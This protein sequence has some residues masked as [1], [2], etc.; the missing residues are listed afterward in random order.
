MTPQ[1]R[2]ALIAKIEALPVQL[3]SLLKGVSDERLDRPYRTG[4]WTSRQVV[5]HLADSHMNA[6]IRMRL[7]LTEENPTLRPYN[8]DA[9]A[10]L[11]DAKSG[12]LEPSLTILRGLHKRW[13]AALR[14]VADDAWQRP[15][16]HPQ[17]GATSLEKQL[18]TYAGHGEKHLAHI[19][20]GIGE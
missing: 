12:P 20:A 17:Y 3:E 5:H 10:E 18:G 2:E 7:I 11:G 6:F 19:R 4:G 8:Q 13:A 16:M 15:A 1:E 14:N 9:W